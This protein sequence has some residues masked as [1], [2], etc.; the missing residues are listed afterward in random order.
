V[1]NPAATEKSA[2]EIFLMYD[3]TSTEVSDYNH[4]PG[5][6]NV[7]NLDGHVDFLQYPGPAPLSRVFAQTQSIVPF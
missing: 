1:N 4:V 6:S 2:S 7:L 5:G 3:S